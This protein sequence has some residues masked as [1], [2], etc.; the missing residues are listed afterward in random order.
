MGGTEDFT[1]AIAVRILAISAARFVALLAASRLIAA[2]G[3]HIRMAGRVA[4][5]IASR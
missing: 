5:A 1:A 3:S 4:P 2:A